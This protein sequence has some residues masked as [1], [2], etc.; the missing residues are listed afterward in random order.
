MSDRALFKEAVQKLLDE[1]LS[2]ARQACGAESEEA[3]QAIPEYIRQAWG[4]WG[5]DPV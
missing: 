1:Y 3:W 4:V 5:A 2:R